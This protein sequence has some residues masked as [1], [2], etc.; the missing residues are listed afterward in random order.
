MAD[1]T[2]AY[3]NDHPVT[4]IALCETLAGIEHSF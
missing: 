3:R 4:G 2:D 1:V